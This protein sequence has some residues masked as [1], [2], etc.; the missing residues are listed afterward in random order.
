MPPSRLSLTPENPCLPLVF[1]DFWVLCPRV[2]LDEDTG[3]S[4][5]FDGMKTPEILQLVSHEYGN[6]LAIES[7][8]I[9]TR[10]YSAQLVLP[11]AL[12]FVNR[13]EGGID[14]IT[15]R[16]S[17]LPKCLVSRHFCWAGSWKMGWRS[18]MFWDL[19]MIVG[20]KWPGKGLCVLL[21]VL[22]DPLEQ[23]FD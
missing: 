9:G 8:G 18:L 23:C 15:N 6:G 11:E 22:K 7:S 4:A 12:E 1:L 5:V 13:F 21:F 17:L 14:G 19:L 3:D 10:D 2:E 16:F 20:A